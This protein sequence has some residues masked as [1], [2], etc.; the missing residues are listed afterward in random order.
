MQNKYNKR[1][2]KVEKK[3]SHTF[4]VSE[5]R[6]GERYPEESD[7]WRKATKKKTIT[8]KIKEN[9]ELTLICVVL[10]THAYV[11]REMQRPNANTLS[12]SLT[13]THTNNTHRKCITL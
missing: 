4:K 10:L 11:Y 8:E 13:H 9:Y 7:D 2:N 1:K 12:H 3:I 6:R 5:M